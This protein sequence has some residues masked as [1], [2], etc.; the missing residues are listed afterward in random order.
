MTTD[1]RALSRFRR[2]A[3]RSRA[4]PRPSASGR[5]AER[6]GAASSGTSRTSIRIPDRRALAERL[7]AATFADT[8]F[9][10]N[11]GAEAIECAIKMARKLSF[12]ERPAR[13]LPHHHLR[14]RLPRP[15]AGDASRPA[16]SRNTSRASARWCRA[17]T[18]SPFGDLE[19]VRGG[20]RPGDG[21]DPDRAD[22]GR[23]RHP[24][25]R[26]REFL[27]GLRA[28]L[29]RARPAADLRR[30]PDRHGPHRQALRPRMGGRHAR[31]HGG[32]Q[33]HRRRLPVGACLATE[34]AAT[35]MTAGTHG[36]TFGGNPLAWR[37][38]TRCSTS[39]WRRASSSSVE[40]AAG[41]LQQR[42]GGLVDDASRRSSRRCA[43]RA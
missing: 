21:G 42:L 1:G 11:S 36:S 37:S 34:E 43:A 30:G 24:R 8:V 16:A 10:S 32:R 33:G 35:G 25:R 3:S 5:G 23:G 28:A 27:R 31:H 4:R 22:P 15:H 38:A 29:R 13:A 40:P 39:C 18:R 7:V 41:C 17:S 19:A 12:G 14:G 6:A 9:F 20:D 26:R 2:A